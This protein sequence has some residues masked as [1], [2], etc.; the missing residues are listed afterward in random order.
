M[1]DER[2]GGALFPAL[3][4][5][6]RGSGIVFRHYSLAPK[7]RRVVFEAVRHIAKA[8]RLVISL[9]GSARLAKA[10][11]ANGSHGR[12]HGAMTVPVHTLPERIAAERH[13]GGLL[14]LSPV[15]PTTSHPR[16]KTLGRARFGALARGAK[17]PIIALGGM[18]RQRAKT[19]KP[20]GIYGWAAIDGL[21]P[22]SQSE[23]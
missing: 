1:T 19:L 12:H 7:E 10:W 16:A 5:L 18:T 2:M 13:R 14:F 8:R 17:A 23:R 6:P 9:A 21:T 15:F 4:A 3:R 20:F 22:C 11:R